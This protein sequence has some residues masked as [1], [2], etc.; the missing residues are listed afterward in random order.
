[1][2][3]AL[4]GVNATFSV[5]AGADHIIN[6][7]DF[8]IPANAV[9]PFV[10]TANVVCSP[11]GFTNVYRDTASWETNLFQPAINLLKT[12]DELSK[13]GDPVDYVITLENNSSID[14]PDL[15]CTVTDALVGV[16]A[17]F[18]VAAGADHIINVNDF[19]IPANAVD[20]FVNTANV[21]CSPEGFTNVY[22]DTASWETDLFQ[23]AINL[24]KTGDELSKIGDPVD[25]VITLENNSSIDTPDLTCTVTDALV[26]VN[27]TFSVAAGADHIINV[28]DFIIPANA[29]DPFVN[30]ANV[31]CSPE[32]F[33]NV[34]RDTASWETNLF[35]PAINLLKTGD[36]LS[37][38]G[39]PVDYVITLENNSSIDT[40]DLTCTVTDALVGV[41]AT[42]SVAAGADH[43][44]N[45]ND[46]IIPANAVDPFV[47]TANV[48]CSPEGFTNVYRDTASWETDLF[49]PAINLL[50][51]GDELSKIGD[52]VDYVI[53]LENNSS[54]DTPDLTCTVTDALVGVNATFSVAAGADHIINVNDFIIPAN[55]VDPFVN[56]ANVVCSPEGFTNVYRDTASWETNLFQPSV[57]LTKVGPDYSKVGDIV[58]YTVTI[59]NT[60]SADTPNLVLADF[61]DNLVSSMDELDLPA[62]C[63]TLAPAASCTFTYDHLVVTG[64]DT[65]L[66]GAHLD[67]TA[68]VLYHPTGFP[69]DIEAEDS[70]VVTLIHPSFTLTKEGDAFSKYDTLAEVPFGDVIDYELTLV[71]TGDVD[72]VL[73][74]LNDSLEPLAA[75]SAECATLVVGETCTFNYSHTVTAT[76]G[77]GLTLVNTATVLYT[78]PAMYALSNVI[79]R[80][81]NWTTTLLHPGFTLDKAC[82]AEPVLVGADAMFEITFCNTGDA[83]LVFTLDEDV[84]EGAILRVAGYEFTIAVGDPCLVLTVTVTD[85]IPSGM[86]FENDVTASI[87][88]ADRYG[89]DNTWSA[90]SSDACTV[91]FWGFTPGFWKN[92]TADSPSG[93]DAWQYTAY[94]PTDDLPFNL[95]TFGG[96]TIKGSNKTY[97]ELKMWDALSLKGG[98]NSKGALEI[99][100]RAGTAA[101]LNASFHETV[102]NE[103]H[104]APDLGTP[105]DIFSITIGGTAYNCTPLENPDGGVYFPCTS[106]DIIAIVNAAIAT[107]ERD[108]MI[109]LAGILDSWNNGWHMIDWSWPVP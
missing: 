24:L 73:G 17:T 4:V 57:S 94:L 105:G 104:P 13:I 64:D 43:I 28:N 101:V 106:A 9:D 83:D 42:F 27:A 44:I 76:E 7:N 81:D 61:T 91:W 21:V 30:T 108:V 78:L 35:Q 20:P 98:T 59:T 96:L 49:Q 11:E 33:T 22:R 8:I 16:N 97:G 48:V 87:G 67:N 32:G 92:H 10:N 68:S 37:K 70:W 103:D 99:L 54:I 6:V 75:L 79:T 58:T 14:T 85:P 66:P 88:L 51:T 52:P 31:V 15:T 69:N 25:Y 100:L 60:S 26:G 34:Y 82:M 29:V 109:S 80:S 23:P 93:H 77:L 63:Q 45:V 12:G 41:N 65:G 50:K 38:I 72:L 74:D 40:P 84:Y 19:I 90:Y 53:T 55:A 95:G 71:N 1:M 62:G 102:D 86:R 39:D 36:E 47:N 5:A 56:T 2:T 3:D 46:F 18:S 89:L 107:H